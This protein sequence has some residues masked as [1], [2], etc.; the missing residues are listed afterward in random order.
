MPYVDFLRSIFHYLALTYASET[1]GTPV[2]LPTDEP[3][4]CENCPFEGYN[5]QTWTPNTGCVCPDCGGVF[6]ITA[7]HRDAAS[8]PYAEVEVNLATTTDARV[9]A[10]EFIR[11]NAGKPIG[12]DFDHADA[13][14]WFANAIMIGQDAGERRTEKKY[15]SPV[16]TSFQALLEKQTAYLKKMENS[17]DGLSGLEAVQAL[18]IV[19]RMNQ[20]LYYLK[21]TPRDTPFDEIWNNQKAWSEAAFGTEARTAGIMH[22]IRKETFE[23]EA[24]PDDHAEWADL[25]ILVIDGARRRGLSA[26]DLLNAVAAK[27]IE[28]GKR[29]WPEKGSVPE[30]APIEHVK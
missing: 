13:I 3:V 24:T 4:F 29:K 26:E 28:N 20:S 27:Q 12:T 7:G 5:V 30:D 25:F 22:H 16:P 8:V 17:L 14:S 10:D 1:G 18:E 15:R 2:E 21:T 6:S 11:L 23:V 9:W 19:Y